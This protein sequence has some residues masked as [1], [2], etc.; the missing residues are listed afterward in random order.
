MAVLPA[1]FRLGSWMSE[2][3][4]RPQTLAREGTIVATQ[5][6]EAFVGT[7]AFLGAFYFSVYLGECCGRPALRH[8]SRRMLCTG[9]AANFVRLRFGN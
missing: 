6:E 9:A 8:L 7:V 3:Q 4:L 5:K 2:R 1:A